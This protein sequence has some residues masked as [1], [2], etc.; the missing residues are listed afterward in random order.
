MGGLGGLLILIL[1]FLS[2]FIFVSFVSGH[3]AL[4]IVLL[5][6][7]VVCLVFLI[8]TIMKIAEQRGL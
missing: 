6:F 7:G 4:T 2:V 3:R 8:A 1:I 5:F